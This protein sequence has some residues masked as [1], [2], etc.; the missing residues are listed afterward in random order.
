M[1]TMQSSS[2]IQ[3]ARAALSECLAGV[4]LAL[5]DLHSANLSI[6]YADLIETLPFITQLQKNI[7]MV[8]LSLQRIED[9]ARRLIK[10]LNVDLNAH[11]ERALASLP[12]QVTGRL[13]NSW[14]H[15]LGGQKA[16]ATVLNGV[17]SVRRHDGY[18]DSSGRHR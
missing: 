16:E 15:G 12:I 1:T 13:A 11:D 5:A 10:R 9:A 8:A 18:P 4:E 17:L 2:K 7:V 3:T 6:Q 14:K